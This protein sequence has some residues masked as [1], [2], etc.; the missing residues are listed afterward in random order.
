MSRPDQLLDILQADI[1]SVLK[2][3]PTIPHAY[4]FTGS[5][6]DFRTRIE[7]ELGTR[8]ANTDGKRGLGIQVLPIAVTAGETNLPGP[9]LK[10]RCQILA[11]EN[12]TLNRNADRGTGMTTSQ[13][14]LNI[15]GALHL[16][17]FGIAS[18][19]A[20]ANP[21]TPEKAEPGFEAHVITLF[22]RSDGYGGP[23]KVAIPWPTEADDII[24]LTTAT[25]G[26]AIYYTT[27]GSY[28]TPDNG[29]L[30]AAPITGAIV[31]TTYRAAAY[32]S[33]L[34]PSDLAQF[35]VSAPA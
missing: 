3:T 27:D 16:H 11:I 32:L 35:V 6:K 26:A 7:K 30:Y 13:A 9:P 20:E 34:N 28:P 33:P 22:C 25:A 17:N 24:T 12:M 14:A 5:E 4:I 31:G 1:V 18:L 15:L 2:N 19:Y 8:T 21:I 29:T 23:G 10:L